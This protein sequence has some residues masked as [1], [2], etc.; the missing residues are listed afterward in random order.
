MR[1]FR[2]PLPI[3]LLTTLLCLSA[4]ASFDSPTPGEMV[5]VKS[6]N[7]SL[8]A[9]ASDNASKQGDLGKFEPVKIL[10]QSGEYS[11][12]QTSDNKTGF[13]KTDQLSP[14][15]FATTDI[16]GGRKVNVRAE[17]TINSPVLFRLETNYPVK[18]IEKKKD[19]LKIVDY[20]GD[21]GWIH[22]N[23]LKIERYV[24]ATPP[25][26][27]EWINMREGPGLDEDRKPI[28][29]K[30][31]VA[32]RGAIFKVLDEKDGWI[33][34]QHADGDEAWCSANIVWGFYD[35]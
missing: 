35:E 24:V 10:E 4:F 26:G 11:Q 13:V 25:E 30:R 22:K 16:S 33:K 6:D 5:L 12:V 14:S 7:V 1:L 21:E 2:T 27:L 23:L 29:P 34:V 19:R 31:F 15:R 9:T 18:V 17:E 3:F 32:Q 28:Y 20:E 8:Y